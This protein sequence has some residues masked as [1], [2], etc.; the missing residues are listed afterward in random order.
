M[1]Y[2]SINLTRTRPPGALFISHVHTTLTYFEQADQPLQGPQRASPPHG[3]VLHSCVSV[4]GPKHGRPSLLGAG[5]VQWRK[6]RCCP[7]PQ[8]TVQSPQSLHS[9]QLPCTVQ[10]TATSTSAWRISLTITVTA[11]NNMTGLLLI[12]VLPEYVQQKIQLGHTCILIRHSLG[13]S[14]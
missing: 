1:A 4:S 9:V 12:S 7:A 13:W 3:S 10:A 2:R 6:R 11:R 8:L 5:A 14:N